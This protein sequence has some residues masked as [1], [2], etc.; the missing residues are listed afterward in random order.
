MQVINLKLY[1]A[2][3]HVTFFNT[4]FVSVP[5]FLYSLQPGN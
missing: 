3:H 4:K 5:V 1:Y 2:S